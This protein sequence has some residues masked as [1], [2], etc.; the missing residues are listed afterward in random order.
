MLSL[1]THRKKCFTFKEMRADGR[2]GD[3]SEHCPLKSVYVNR[4]RMLKMIWEA[5][6]P[7]QSVSGMTKMVM[8]RGGPRWKEA[9]ETGYSKSPAHK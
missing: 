8:G 2:E 4:F 6:R 3:I 7:L 5:V 9:E 1:E